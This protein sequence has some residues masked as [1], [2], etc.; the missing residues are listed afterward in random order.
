MRTCGTE[1]LASRGCRSSL[2]SARARSTARCASRSTWARCRAEAAHAPARSEHSCSHFEAGE[3]LN[4]P[5][6]ASSSPADLVQ[7]NASA[8]NAGVVAQLRAG[9][10]RGLR[11]RLLPLREPDSTPYCEQHLPRP[12]ALGVGSCRG[13]APGVPRQTAPAAPVPGTGELQHLRTSTVLP[14]GHIAPPKQDTR[15]RPG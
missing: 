4:R 15:R 11:P 10:R 14:S 13:V 7:A 6:I 8:G 12:R 2:R 9:G 1:V 5:T 3:R